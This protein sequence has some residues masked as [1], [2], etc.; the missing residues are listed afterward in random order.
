MFKKSY[1][2]ILLLII[3]G[4]LMYFLSSFTIISWDNVGYYLYL[5]AKFIWKDIFL[6]NYTFLEDLII[7][8]YGL[9]GTLYQLV[10]LEDGAYMIK[11][12]SGISILHFPFFLIT[13]F[14]VQTFTSYPA[15]G[16]S[17]PY[18]I[19]FWIS[20]VFYTLLGFLFLIKALNRLFEQRTALVTIIIFILGLNFLYMFELSTIV[21]NYAF[22]LYSI[23]LW[24][25][26]K[27][28]EQKNLINTIFL[29]L[30]YG[31]IIAVRPP[32]GIII[33]VFF[34]WQVSN[35][36]EFIAKL[37][38]FLS[39][40]KI[41]LIFIIAVIIPFIPQMIYWITLTGKLV[42]NSYSNPGEGFDFLSPHTL[43]FLFSFR[44]GWIIYS[45]IILF[46]IPAFIMLYRKKREYFYATFVFLLISV[47]LHSS[48]T[49]WWYAESYGQRSMLQSYVVLAVPFGFFVNHILNSRKKLKTL[50][51]FVI[52]VFILFNI[53]KY[54][55]FRMRI[56]H[57]SRMTRAYYFATFFSVHK[58]DKQT[59]RLLLVERPTTNNVEFRNKEDYNLKLK[60]TIDYKQLQVPEERLIFVDTFNTYFVRL[61][62]TY[63]FTPAFRMTFESITQF[64][65]AYLIVNSR[66]YNSYYSLNNPLSLVATFQHRG[67][68]YAYRAINTETLHQGR[69]SLQMKNLT[70]IYLTPEVRRKN[71]ELLIYY[72]LRGKY[73]VLVGPIDIE[74]WEPRKIQ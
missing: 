50:M 54:Y 25:M 42:V 44:K 15:D 46:L 12:T 48:W 11:Y 5:P 9:S 14:L 51:F 52:G 45:P 63:I 20:T 18:Q 66:Y 8:Q 73:E 24:Q 49:C 61:D 74:I 17:D 23:F 71:D 28:Y 31:F 55:Q 27:W 72:W 64:D 16:F 32:D 10:M 58:P 53:F 4:F 41:T 26:L 39:N 40:L 21:H 65:H 59:E 2:Q 1:L 56:I 33:V 69:D 34:L 35:F 30:I 43:N 70:M 62:S 22:A 7:K 13:H 68:N 36:H 3:L 19:S 38:W 57:P 37:K 29:G 60:F 6:R 67:G 47:Y